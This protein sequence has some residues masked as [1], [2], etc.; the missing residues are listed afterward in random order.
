LVLHNIKVSGYNIL[1]VFEPY[2]IVLF[3]VKYLFVFVNF[4]NKRLHNSTAIS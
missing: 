4:N 1:L 3:T 2:K